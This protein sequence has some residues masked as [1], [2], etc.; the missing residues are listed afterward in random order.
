[1]NHDILAG[2]L[3]GYAFVLLVV[4]PAYFYFTGRT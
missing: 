1:M 4:I 3:L 2:L